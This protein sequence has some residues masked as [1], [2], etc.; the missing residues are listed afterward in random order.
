MDLRRMIK[1]FF[2]KLFC[3]HTVKDEVGYSRRRRR[4]VYQCCKCGKF[5][6]SR[7]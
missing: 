4:K 6:Y 3:K 5:F 7:Y 1:R 2:R